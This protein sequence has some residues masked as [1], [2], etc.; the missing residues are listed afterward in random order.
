MPSIKRILSFKFRRKRRF[1]AR[2]GLFVLF[3]NSTT[4]NQ[5]FDINM[6]G[7]S[8]Y[9][10]DQG[11]KP[12]EGL[13]KLTLITHNH[14]LMGKVPCKE[15]SDVESAEIRFHTKKIKR[16]SVQ[17]GRLSFGQKSKLKEIIKKFT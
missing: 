13:N 11:I 15:V 6:R 1:R 4:P 12:R 14:I 10:V 5:V 2:D 8:F 16:Q 7:L 17:F 9:Y 3:G